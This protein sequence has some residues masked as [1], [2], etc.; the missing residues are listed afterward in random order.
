M[1]DPFVLLKT[2]PWD[3]TMDLSKGRQTMIDEKAAE[4]SSLS[5][6]KAE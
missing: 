3:P 6:Q 2:G 4:A 1:K 5:K